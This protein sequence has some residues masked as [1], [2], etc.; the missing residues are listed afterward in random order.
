MLQNP[1]ILALA[2]L[3][4]FSVLSPA[5]QAQS[6]VWVVDD[7]GGAGV[8][9]TL[10]QDAIDAAAEGDVLLLSAGT[11]DPRPIFRRHRRPSTASP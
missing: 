1:W 11:Y 4:L 3:G 6:A 2:V 9:F 8:D 10:L 7:D 5:T